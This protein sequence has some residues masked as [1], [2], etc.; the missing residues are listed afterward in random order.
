MN[1]LAINMT[2]EHEVLENGSESWYVLDGL[3]PGDVVTFNNLQS[4]KDYITNI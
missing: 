3:N 4:A 2:I 1:K